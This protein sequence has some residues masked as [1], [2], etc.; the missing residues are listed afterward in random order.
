MSRSGFYARTFR[1]STDHKYT[2]KPQIEPKLRYGLYTLLC[3]RPFY[4]N[5]FIG[6]VCLRSFPFLVPEISATK[7][8]VAIFV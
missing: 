7:E 4:L 2:K 1:F 5:R 8:S 6:N 3:N